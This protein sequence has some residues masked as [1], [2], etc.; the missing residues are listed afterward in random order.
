VLLFAAGV[1]VVCHLC[2]CDCL[3]WLSTSRAEHVL[4]FLRLLGTHP[5][6]RTPDEWAEHPR[7][8]TPTAGVAFKTP[9]LARLFVVSYC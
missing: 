3:L 9:L 1:V 2:C 8:P 6:S 7:G 4:G 5:A